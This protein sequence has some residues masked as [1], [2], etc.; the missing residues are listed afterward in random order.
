MLGPCGPGRS[1]GSVFLFG[2]WSKSQRREDSGIDLAIVSADFASMGYLERMEALANAVAT[3]RA[4]IEAVAVTPD[5]F[6]NTDRQQ[7]L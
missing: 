5:E 6:K 7:E 1:S 4:P 3:V 2:S